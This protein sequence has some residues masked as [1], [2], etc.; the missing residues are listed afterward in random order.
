MSSDSHAH[1]AAH[2]DREIEEDVLAVPFIAWL[3]VTGV[4]LIVASV[5]ALTGMYYQTQNALTRARYAEAESRLTPAEAK[6]AADA[7][8]V[9]GYYR[10]VPSPEG[11]VAPEPGQEP[12]QYVSVPVHEYGK[13]KVLEQYGR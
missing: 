8:V 6:V 12:K 2:P 9:E 3:G 4:I 10:G 11:A 1:P 7:V 5:L 13:R